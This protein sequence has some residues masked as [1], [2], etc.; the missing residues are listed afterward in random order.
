M[1]TYVVGT[2]LNHLSETVQ[3]STHNIC[4]HWKIR[5]IILQLSAIYSSYLVYWQVKQCPNKPYS[6][7]I[8]NWTARAKI[9][10]VISPPPH[11]SPAPINHHTTFLDR[12][13]I[14]LSFVPWSLIMLLMQIKFIYNRWKLDLIPLLFSFLYINA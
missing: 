5:K 7:Q 12:E 2:H 6:L 13:G 9:F 11:P 1:K 8:L 3:M 10:F 4:F 14:V